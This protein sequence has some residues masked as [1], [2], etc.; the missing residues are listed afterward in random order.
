VMQGADNVVD[1]PIDLSPGVRSD[2]RLIVS[3]RGATLTGS[4][5]DG[6]G[7][8]VALCDV[9]VYPDANDPPESWMT[10]VRR[11]LADSH[12]RFQMDG[13]PPGRYLVIAAD[14]QIGA[15]VDQDAWATI[16]EGATPVAL[17]ERERREL[18]LQLVAWPY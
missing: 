6:A 8:P 12:G 1:A 11:A 9:R 2:L 10:G 17:G 14:R 15:P 7:R 4:V 3:N 5:E 18:R 16:R 13:I